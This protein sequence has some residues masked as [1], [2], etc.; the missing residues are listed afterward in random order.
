LRADLPVDQQRNY[1]LH[2]LGGG[3]LFIALQF[4]S[5][6]LVIPWIDGHLGVAYILVASGVA[7]VRVGVFVARRGGAPLF[8][9]VRLR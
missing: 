3:A 1:L 6:R 7:V 9:R 8:S 5:V 2:L 4:G